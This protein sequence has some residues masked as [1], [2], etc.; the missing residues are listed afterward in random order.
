MAN[1][2]N[3]RVPIGVWRRRI[4][5]CVFGVVSTTL[6]MVLFFAAFLVMSGVLEW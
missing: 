3:G 4:T 5:F 6:G 2:G 1:I